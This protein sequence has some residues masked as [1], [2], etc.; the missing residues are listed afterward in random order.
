MRHV[1]GPEQPQDPDMLA[2]CNC[3]SV[4]SPIPKSTVDGIS[5]Y[6]TS[7]VLIPLMAT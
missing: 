5:D 7:K 1:E 3:A 4:E 6:V 2:S